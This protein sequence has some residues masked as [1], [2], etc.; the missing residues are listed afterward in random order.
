MRLLFDCGGFFMTNKKI[1]NVRHEI[2]YICVGLIVALFLSMVFTGFAAVVFSLLK[3]YFKAAIRPISLLCLAAGC[4]ISTYICGR[5]KKNGGVLTGFL[6]ACFTLIVISIIY[7]TFDKALFTSGSI[8][9][10]ITVIL[11]GCCGGYLG[12]ARKR[13]RR[14]I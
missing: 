4:F 14:R 2:T 1:L 8:I 11:S 9:K 6:V 3:K 7:L 5:T 13:P 10:S 12:N